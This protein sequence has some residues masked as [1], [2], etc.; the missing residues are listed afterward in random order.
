MSSRST[1]FLV[2]GL[3][4]TQLRD[5]VSGQL[6]WLN[7]EL[8]LECPSSLMEYLDLHYDTETKS[9][10]TVRGVVPGG[11]VGD[12]H[13]IKMITEP[14]MCAGGQFEQFVRYL[15]AIGG[16]KEGKDLFGVP[17][18]WRLILDTTYWQALSRSLQLSIEKNTGGCSSTRATLIG[19][20]L[21]GLVITRF[22]LEQTPDW[23]MKFIKKVIFVGVPLG[24]CPKAFISVCGTIEDLPGYN[25]PCVRRFLQRCS[26]A[27]MCHPVADAFPRLTIIKN[28]WNPETKSVQSFGVG[29][30]L[31][32]YQHPRFRTKSAY[33]IYSDYGN[34][35][36]SLT[37]RGLG[38]NIELHIVYSSVKD[39]TVALDY[40][41]GSQGHKVRESDYYRHL[42]PKKKGKE[43]RI[44]D[45][46]CPDL[47]PAEDALCV[48]GDG[49]VPYFSL[50]Y[51]DKKCY[52]DGRPYAQSIKKF[53]GRQ[54]DHAEMFNRTEIVQYVYEL[55]DVTCLDHRL[56]PIVHAGSVGV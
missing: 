53:V 45:E 30:L 40:R 42:R 38:E 14:P 36:N 19:F 18:D 51:W 54:Y 50:S 34:V 12:L 13:S 37:S 29:E 24:G 3:T 55:L 23:K 17:Y 48:V 11:D 43:P 52:P 25:T 46:C 33:D 39:T 20:S 1:I 7:P 28:V 4:G 8:M 32:A 22:L 2:P 35:I 31:Q 47:E 49:M 16:Y 44:P 26:G 15:V 9:F 6:L 56:E 21:G 10:R 5:C 27:F 41:G